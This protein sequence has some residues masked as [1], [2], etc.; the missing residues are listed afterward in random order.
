MRVSKR[1]F[2]SKLLAKVDQK[3]KGKETEESF[4]LKTFK[5]MDIGRTGRVN[6]SQFSEALARMGLPLD[7]AVLLWF[8]QNLKTVFDI[9]DKDKNQLI[10]YK[11]FAHSVLGIETQ[12]KPTVNDTEK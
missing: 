10:D 6:Y 2:E 12:K 4:I 11:E 7:E 5:Y 1:D 3:L 9:Y 8:I